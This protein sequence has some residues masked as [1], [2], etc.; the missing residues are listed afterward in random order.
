MSVGDNCVVSASPSRQAAED[1]MILTSILILAFTP[2]QA[3]ADD[4]DIER[5]VK[6]LTSAEEDE[7]DRAVMQ[8]SGLTLERARLLAPHV[9]ALLKSD[10]VATRKSAVQTVDV[11][12]LKELEPELTPRLKDSD[13]WVRVL[14][15]RAIAGIRAEK[16]YPS[17]ADALKSGS[18][19]CRV[20]AAECLGYTR[21]PQAV[22]ALMAALQDKDP[23]V[24]DKAA[25]SLGRLR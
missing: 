6:G 23:S 12:R 20:E 14:T 3:P 17:L 5:I 11:L 1:A 4:R 24:A 10:N 9:V 21:F 25:E 8:A 18:P 15:I 19:E 16:L 13:V 7:S 22:P 2:I